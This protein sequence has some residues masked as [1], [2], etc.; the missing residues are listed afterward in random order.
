M[1]HSV[2]LVSVVKGL[3]APG[4]FPAGKAP[5]SIWLV[6]LSAG[7][8]PPDEHALVLNVNLNLGTISPNLGRVPYRLLRSAGGV[9]KTHLE[10]FSHGI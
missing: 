7:N 3:V 4:A 1:S 9:G 2:I 5:K 6:P 8:W 10:S